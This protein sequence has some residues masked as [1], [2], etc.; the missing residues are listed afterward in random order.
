MTVLERALFEYQR[1]AVEVMAGRRATLLA[2][3]PG[4][5]KT[6][7]VLG[8][9]ASKGLFDESEYPSAIL[10]LCPI[11]AAQSAWIASIDRFV[12]DDYNV[13][14]VDLSHG[15]TVQ[16]RARLREFLAQDSMN[17]FIVVANY[18]AVERL[19]SEYRLP[20]L[21]GLQFDAVVVD[22]SH[23]VLPILNDRRLTNFWKG[24]KTFDR[25][26]HRFAVSGTP[27]RG[28]LENR[29]GTYRF[30]EP[31][32]FATVSRW[33]WME[34]NFHV[35]ERQVARNRTVKAIGEV[36]SLSAWGFEEDRLIIRRTKVEVL[37][38][39]PAKQYNFIEVELHPE[40]RKQY[41]DAVRACVE[42]K[43][44]AME[45]DVDTA[46]AMVFATRARQIS[47]C[48]WGEAGPLADGKSSKLDWLL[49]WLA[50][51]EE[52]KVVV[53]SQFVQVLNWLQVK[54]S[55]A[56]YRV[57]VLDGSLNGPA[58]ASVQA[59]FQDGD[60]QVVLLSGNMGVGITLDAADDLILFDLPYDPDK[61]EQIED[62]VHRASRN[63]QVTI[64]T[65]L[66][67]GT[68]DQVVAS[69]VNS[70]Y[71]VTRA[72]MDG[73]RGVEFERRILDRIRVSRKVEA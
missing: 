1:E 56:G 8:A 69:T 14:I 41:G 61:I 52:V 12:L 16:K 23:M 33:S 64:W 44:D 26:P 21:M 3:Q 57:A 34:N 49:E 70:R 63:H 66:G 42:D 50:E 59:E 25:V 17:P 28:K 29:Y 38:D 4:L 18:T 30:L 19:K 53:S 73:R 54:L 11:V 32:R 9:L 62:R 13:D 36:K 47:A 22:E 6:V 67:V 2:D 65:L 43:L 7:E 24:L 55:E 31:E 46:A 10:I 58:K 20:E 15:S 45:R 5:G 51:R 40:Q 60:L 71:K 68:V 39:L 48:Q 27:D 35:F 72:V 37:T